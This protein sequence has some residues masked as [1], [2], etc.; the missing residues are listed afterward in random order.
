MRALT[1][2]LVEEAR[3]GRRMRL[4]EFSFPRA[5]GGGL[6]EAPVRDMGEGTG[7]SYARAA[8]QAIARCCRQQER[9]DS[10]LSGASL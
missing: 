9:E 7:S 4:G 1:F 3:S 10:N 5:T 8:K 6:R 2:C